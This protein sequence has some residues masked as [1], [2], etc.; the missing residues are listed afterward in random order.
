[1]FLRI[2]VSE[3]ATFAAF[4]RPAPPLPNPTRSAD[5]P[6]RK[7]SVAAQEPR[8]IAPDPRRLAMGLDAPRTQPRKLS[9]LLEAEILAGKKVNA[10]AA[11]MLG[12]CL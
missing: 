12:L 8:R 4:I 11:R 6:H 5:H 10:I 1:M 2:A 7:Y 3:P 9:G